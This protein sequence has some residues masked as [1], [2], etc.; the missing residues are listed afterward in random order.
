M[1]P[2]TQNFKAFSIKDRRL[3]INAE[4]RELPKLCLLSK[5]SLQL[6]TDRLEEQNVPESAINEFKGG[7]A[8]IIKE[9][10]KFDSGVLARKNLDYNPPPKTLVITPSDKT[11]RLIALDVEWRREVIVDG[12]VPEDRGYTWRIAPSGRKK[13]L[14]SHF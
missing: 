8:L 10:E 13:G 4:P 6:T 9:C 12:R 1:K 2:F 14:P 7:I 5:D 11:K 3:F